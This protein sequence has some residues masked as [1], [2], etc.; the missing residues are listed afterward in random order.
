MAMT[1]QLVDNHKRIEAV[2]EDVRLACSRVTMA[3]MDL[4]RSE[5]S[6]RDA[7]LDQPIMDITTL[8]Q[9]QTEIKALIRARTELGNA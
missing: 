8:V 3:L 7:D 2:M 1:R 4:S 6:L 9:L 5:T